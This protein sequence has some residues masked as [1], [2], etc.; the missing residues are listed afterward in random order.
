LS[1]GIG[2]RLTS[3]SFTLRKAYQRISTVKPSIVIVAAIITAFSLFLLS[4]GVYDILEQPMAAIPYGKTIL[5]YYPYTLA[6]QAVIESIGVMIAYAMGA[7]GLLLMYQSTKF[8]YKPRQAFMLLI[9]GIALILIAYV[10]I[11]SLVFQKL[12]PPQQTTTSS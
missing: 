3:F 7:I 11:E 8:A 6:A 10:Y 5:F 12:N 1:P 2:R 9:S 4:G